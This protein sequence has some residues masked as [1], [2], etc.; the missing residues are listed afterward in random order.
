MIGD[1][2]T[3]ANL[4]AIK[5]AMD[6]IKSNDRSDYFNSYYQEVID[7]IEVKK[8]DKLYENARR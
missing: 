4:S 2:L 6:N 3:L 8:K 7:R 1:T 5:K